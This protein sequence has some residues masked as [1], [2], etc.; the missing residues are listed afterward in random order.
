MENVRPL[1]LI[2][3]M[4]MVPKIDLG[5]VLSFATRSCGSLSLAFKPAE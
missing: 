4:A 1:L 5:M 2:V 3:L